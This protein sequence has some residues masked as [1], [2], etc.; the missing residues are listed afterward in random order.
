MGAGY[1]GGFGNTLGAVAGDAV[2][3][4]QPLVFFKY[5][6]RRPD[7]DPAGVFDIAVHGRIFAIT[8]NHNNRTVDLDARVVA[9]LIKQRKDY[10]AGQNIRL[11]SCNTGAA[12]NGFAQSLADQLNVIVEAPNKMLWALEN[13][14]YFVA[15]GKQLNDRWIPIMSDMGKLVKFYPGGYRNGKNR[16]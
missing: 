15:G 8:I 1:H 2:F 7:I 6:S 4:S 9:K 14:R 11:L 5:I 13:G 3:P 10:K 12:A 16:M